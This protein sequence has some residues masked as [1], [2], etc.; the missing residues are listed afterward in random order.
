MWRNWRR[1]DEKAVA[2]KGSGEVAEW[3]GAS[4]STRV[5]SIVCVGVRVW[6][7]G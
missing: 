3:Y 6:A 4:C 5:V 2:G 1:H 7:K